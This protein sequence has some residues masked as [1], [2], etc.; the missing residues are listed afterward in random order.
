MAYV[1]SVISRGIRVS[2]GRGSGSG[3]H[4]T[5][6]QSSLTGS[7]CSLGATDTASAIVVVKNVHWLFHWTLVGNGGTETWRL[8]RYPQAMAWKAEHVGSQWTLCRNGSG[9]R[10]KCCHALDQKCTCWH[11]GNSCNR[12][13]FIH[14]AGHRRA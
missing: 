14:P 12:H 5:G 7:Q 10:C 1:G 3:A 2:P 9:K 8:R 13:F 11:M 4:S 6:W